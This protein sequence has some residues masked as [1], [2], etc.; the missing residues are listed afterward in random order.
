MRNELAGKQ[1]EKANL[2][3]TISQKEASSGQL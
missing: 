3:N 2:V 1:S